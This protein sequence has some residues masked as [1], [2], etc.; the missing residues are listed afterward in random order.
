MDWQWGGTRLFVVCKACSALSASLLP[1]GAGRE[2]V[3]RKQASSSGFLSDRGG[4]EWQPAFWTACGQCPGSTTEAACLAGLV[5]SVVSEMWEEEMV[6]SIW[7]ETRMKGLLGA[8]LVFWLTSIAPRPFVT[9]QSEQSILWEL[10][11]GS[12]LVGNGA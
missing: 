1:R 4:S 6:W 10:C 8:R 12:C 2:N 5:P 3:W 7:T 11:E 9:C